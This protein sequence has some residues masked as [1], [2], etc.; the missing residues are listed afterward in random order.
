MRAVDAKESFNGKGNPVIAFREDTYPRQFLPELAAFFAQQRRRLGAATSSS[1][2][3]ELLNDA[4]SHLSVNVNELI[5]H[6]DSL[7]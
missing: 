7:L 4:A 2:A 3:A 6:I 5:R 1:Q